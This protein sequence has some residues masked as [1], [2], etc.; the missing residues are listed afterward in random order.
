MRRDDFVDFFLVEPHQ[1]EIHKRLENWAKWCFG[2]YGSSASPMFRLY[3]ADNWERG[4]TAIPVDG[5][6]A[7]KIAK[8]VALLPALH[9]EALQW[10]YVTGGSPTKAR[11]KL[12][13]TTQGLMQLIRDGRQMLINRQV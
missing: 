4:S 2:P 1:Q 7:Q 11:K 8:G 3:R 9:R 10:N 13:V 6:D 5:A 12:G